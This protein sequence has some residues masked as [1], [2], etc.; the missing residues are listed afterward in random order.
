MFSQSPELASPKTTWESTL[1]TLKYSF[2]S[3][4]FAALLL[5]T[6]QT[7]QF[8]FKRLRKELKRTGQ[9]SSGRLLYLVERIVSYV[10]G[11]TSAVTTYTI[12]YSSLQNS[13]FLSSAAKCTRLF[14]RNLI[15]GMSATLMTR[16]VFVCGTYLASTVVMLGVLHFYNME[17]NVLRT[18]Y[19]GV[20]VWGIMPYFSV[21]FLGH[22]VLD[23]VDAMF[24]CY[25]VDLDRNECLSEPIHQVFATLVDEE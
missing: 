17:L 20:G 21:R 9:Y 7:I 24:V 15:I 13:S 5:S 2:G 22:L 3:I 14:Q 11:L 4:S 18:G 23:I 8:L 19:L 6:F 1:A 16:I 10:Y 12:I 25:V